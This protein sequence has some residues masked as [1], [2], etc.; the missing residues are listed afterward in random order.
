MYGRYD[1]YIWETLLGQTVSGW[2]GVLQ[3]IEELPNS[4]YCVFT[5]RDRYKPKPWDCALG[6]PFY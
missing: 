5:K 2:W 4:V 3:G 1:I 6:Y